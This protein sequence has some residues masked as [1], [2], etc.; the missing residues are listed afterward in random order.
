VGGAGPPNGFLEIT[1]E[2]R[3]LYE[4]RIKQPGKAATLYRGSKA[5]YYQLMYKLSF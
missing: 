4:E 1:A 2:R 5:I 3:P